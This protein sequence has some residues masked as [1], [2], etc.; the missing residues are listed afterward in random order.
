MGLNIAVSILAAILSARPARTSSPDGTGWAQLMVDNQGPQEGSLLLLFL[1]GL[2]TMG[3]EVVWIRLFTPSI[4]PMVYSFALIL[5][6][7][8]FATFVGSR[9]YRFWSR[10]Y[11]VEGA[12]I[13]VLL[14][15]LGILP[16]VTT[17]LRSHFMLPVL[18]VLIGVMPFSAAIGFLTPML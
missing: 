9:I 18:R 6:S 4:G 17:D 12:M 5:A 2:I 11:S 15:L 1:T 8:L 10:K 7:Y 16:L 3:M 13:W 14:A